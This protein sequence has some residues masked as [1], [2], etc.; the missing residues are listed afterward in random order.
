MV[1]R[2]TDAALGRAPVRTW[3][4]R[5]V[6]G[7]HGRVLEIGF[8]SGLNLDLLPAEVTAVDAVEPLDAGWAASAR[9][10]AGAGVPVTR[11]GLDGQS[12]DL[13]DA[14]SGTGGYD[15]ALCTFSL[16]TIPDPLLALRE[17]R[18]VLPAGAARH[19]LEHTR[20]PSPRVQRWQ[21]RVEPAQRVVFGGC[22]L[23]RDPL[24]LARRAGFEV[25]DAEHHVLAGGPLTPWTHLTRARV[26]VP[27][28]TASVVGA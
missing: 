13:P 10:R 18:R 27:P 24:D 5:T 26:V 2:L 8:G 11:I 28:A 22:H 15:A 23:T 20:S 6:A 4:R 9:R 25:T 17:L 12:L 3:R 21:Q 16:C 1:P 19:L 7:L 14:G